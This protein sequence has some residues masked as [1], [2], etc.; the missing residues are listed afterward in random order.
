[1]K[2]KSSIIAQIIEFNELFEDPPQSVEFYLSGINKDT[3]LRR[4]CYFS[5]SNQCEELY[6][7]TNILWPFFSR[8]DQTILLDVEKKLKPLLANRNKYFIIINARTS[9]KLFEHAFKLDCKN[10]ST[11]SE[12]EINLSLF[13]A[14]LLLNEQY[15]AL[16]SNQENT[17][18]EE[19]ILFSELRNGLYKQDFASLY[20][21]HI[22]QLIKASILFEYCELNIPTHIKEF[23]SYYGIVSWKE[24]ICSIHQI[25]KGVIDNRDKNT[26]HDSIIIEI[27]D[28]KYYFKKQFLEKLCI[29]SIETGN[30]DFTIMKNN[31][32][33]KASDTE[34][35]IISTQ[36]LIEKIFKSIYFTLRT[37]NDRL[38]GEETYIPKGTFRANYG[39]DFT[40]KTLLDT[41]LNKSFS[42]RYKR[43]SYKELTDDGDPDYYIRNG[44]KIFLFECKDNLMK[45]EI[46]DNGKKDEFI[47]ELRHIFIEKNNRGK[48]KPSAIKQLCKNIERITT[49]QFK[50]DE[51]KSKNLIIYPLIVVNHDIYSLSGMNAVINKWFEDELNSKSLTSHNIKDIIL[52][53]MNTLVLCIDLFKEKE[54]TLEKLLDG[55]ISINKKMSCK[56]YPTE[57]DPI[58]DLPQKFKS[59]KSYVE[60]LLR[61]KDI[62][63]KELCKKLSSIFN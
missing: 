49:N 33:V 56:M 17:T 38:V 30:E 22:S 4:A 3:L 6:K 19:I 26:I 40:E 46:I 2:N 9:L 35:L 32:I 18:T 62:F 52:V 45:K 47:N 57:M 53:D 41:I 20:Y 1:M 10:I 27:T 39:Y 25:V 60:D 7:T 44:N 42:K 51:V 54:I 50:K 8:E 43:L 55:Y 12:S 5:Q 16:D 31:P 24:Y 61:D 36:F 63:G 58:N 59:F 34:Y 15:K 23:L 11:K 28:K 29:K 21:L 37:I 13:K 14:Y 48:N